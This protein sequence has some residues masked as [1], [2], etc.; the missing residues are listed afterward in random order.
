M[1]NMNETPLFASVLSQNKK[2]EKAIPSKDYFMEFLTEQEGDKV[3]SYNQYHC[4]WNWLNEASLKG[5]F[6]RFKKLIKT[7]KMT[8]QAMNNNE[9]QLVNT[10][11]DNFGRTYYSLTIQL[12]GDDGEIKQ[13]AFCV[14][15][16]EVFRY[17]ITGFVYHF[18]NVKDRDN[19][20]KYLSK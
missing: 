18:F 19:F 3:F 1:T 9:H 15:S 6:K 7:K 8:I 12:L 5:E 13:G 11:R 14:G 10:D 2:Q 16:F 17:M 20:Y 4:Q